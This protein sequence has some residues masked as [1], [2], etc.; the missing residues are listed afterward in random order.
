MLA[1]EDVSKVSFG[2]AIGKMIVNGMDVN[3]VC[4]KFREVFEQ[5]IYRIKKVYNQRFAKLRQDMTTRRQ[6]LVSHGLNEEAIKQ[7][8]N[9]EFIQDLHTLENERNKK[10]EDVR[11]MIRTMIDE[12]VR[13][14]SRIDK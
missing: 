7:R 8:I 14:F 4:A 3:T 12:T 9:S 2:D 13:R 10:I 6:E 11:M 5:A 1:A